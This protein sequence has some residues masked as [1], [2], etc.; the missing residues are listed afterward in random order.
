MRG[1]L[2]DPRTGWWREENPRD[3]EEIKGL[4]SADELENAALKLGAEYY[5]CYCDAEAREK[6]YGPDTVV[7]RIKKGLRR[8]VRY[9]GYIAGPVFIYLNKG[10]EDIDVEFI[11]KRIILHSDGDSP[12]LIVED[13]QDMTY[14]VTDP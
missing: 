10:L 9:F 6:D 5:G 11:K 8:K 7:M 3:L 12:C 14:E 4:L 2:I 1:I 13:F